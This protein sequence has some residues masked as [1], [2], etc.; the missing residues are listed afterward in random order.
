MDE[1]KDEIV[2]TRVGCLG[3]SDAKLIA[4]VAEHGSVPASAKKRLAICKGLIPH[5]TFTSPAIEFGNYIEGMVFDMLHDGDERWQ[6]NPCLVSE[7]YSRSNCK[8]IDHVDFYLQDDNKK[9][10]TIGECKATKHTYAQTRDEY[11]FQLLHHYLLGCEKAAELGGYKVSVLLCHY[12]TEGLN[13]E[14]MNE[15]DPNRLTVKKLK[16]LESM[17]KKYDIARGMDIIDE[18]L[19][20]FDTYYVGE[21]ISSVYLP[22]DTKKQFYLIAQIIKKIDEDKQK[23]ETF[24]NN[25]FA[26]MS[27][28]DIKS[29]KDAEGRWAI[30]RVDATSVKSVDT[31]KMFDDYCAEHPVKGRKLAK[32]YTTIT[33]KKGYC[34]IKQNKK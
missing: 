11:N 4:S 5:E 33:D 23:V 26:F 18:F 32:Q 12:C 3:G 15:F 34:S 21:E 9:T 17:S 28:N 14:D 31:K 27:K 24:K 2:S 22:A 29:I 7:K 16:N 30:T 20:T 13:L 1:H 8:V 10:I 25:L 6:S 19:S